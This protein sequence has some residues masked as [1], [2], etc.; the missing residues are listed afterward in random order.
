MDCD[1][2][3]NDGNKEGTK[4]VDSFSLYTNIINSLHKA[5]II[6]RIQKTNSSFASEIRNVYHAERMYLSI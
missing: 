4:M 1:E 3:G 6:P 5:W 2:N